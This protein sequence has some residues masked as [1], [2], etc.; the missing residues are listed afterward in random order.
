M[1]QQ[2]RLAK[3]LTNLGIQYPTA[4]RMIQN[5]GTD[6]DPA[7]DEA[8]A[9]KTLDP[10][11]GPFTWAVGHDTDLDQILDGAGVQYAHGSSGSGLPMLLIA[12]AQWQHAHGRSQVLVSLY[13][14][15]IIRGPSDVGFGPDRIT[16]INLGDDIPPHRDG[17]VLC[18]LRTEQAN[19][20]DMVEL[21]S[22]LSGA[23]WT[24]TT[25][26][27]LEPLQETTG[28]G[29]IEEQ[30]AQAGIALRCLSN[31]PVHEN[32]WVGHP[33]SPEDRGTAAPRRFT[34][35]EGNNPVRVQLTADFTRP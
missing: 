14:L 30:A 33:L 2:H 6:L 29:E 24:K 12:L 20:T 9:T 18:V 21:I 22:A 17:H 27:L 16:T 26:S 4:L 19:H 35:W 23:G 1:A 7:P 10:G 5:T 32:V 8:I 34:Y 31:Y 28:E 15:D 11:T 25:L 3:A 13:P